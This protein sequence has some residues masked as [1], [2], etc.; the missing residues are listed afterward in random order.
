MARPPDDV[1]LIGLAEALADYPQVR[2]DEST[3]AMVRQGRVLPRDL[4]S[5]LV[6]G[7]FTGDGP[8]AVVGPDGELL[9]VYE[10]H[11]ASDVKPAVV[12]AV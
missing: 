4:A 5:G 6:G 8:W 10:P 11:R 7:A 9:A 3:A 1:G 12:V 2:L